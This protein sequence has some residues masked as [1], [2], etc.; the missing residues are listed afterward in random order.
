MYIQ[1]ELINEI[2]DKDVI[3]FVG[4]GLTMNLGLP[5]WTKLIEVMAKDLG[6]DFNQFKNSGDFYEL[7]EYYKLKKGSIG[8]IRSWMDINFHSN[9]DAIQDSKIFWLLNELEFPIIYTT[10][11][12]RWLEFSFE[13]Y[14]KPYTKISNIFDLTKI[15]KDSI[16]LIKFHGDFDD[17]DSI[18]LSESSYFERLA[19][20]SPLDMKLRSDTL[21]KTILFI[22]YSLSDINIRYMFYKLNKYWSQSNYQGVKPK[23]YIFM[24]D[25]NPVKQL[26]L[27][28]KGIETIVSPIEDNTKALE[29]F[30]SRLHQECILNNKI[31]Q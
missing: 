27:K 1:Q 12:D 24:V 31:N 22:G 13:H 3:L 28:E 19:L 2:R 15:E 14:K 21:G 5:S 20:D 7:A 29:D 17:D 18:V 8:S 26:L 16:Q 10:N 23:S 30:L 25:E 6:I 4:A 11:Y 9:K